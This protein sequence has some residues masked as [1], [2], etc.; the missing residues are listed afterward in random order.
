MVVKGSDWECD[1]KG[2]E[3]HMLEGD[4]ARPNWKSG[5]FDYERMKREVCGDEHGWGK[6][7]R[8]CEEQCTIVLAARGRGSQAAGDRVCRKEAGMEEDTEVAS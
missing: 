1:E 7:H 4:S 5:K 2:F 6:A 3:Q 8:C